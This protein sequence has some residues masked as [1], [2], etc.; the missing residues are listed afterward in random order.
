[1]VGNGCYDNFPMR[2]MMYADLIVRRV[3]LADLAEVKSLAM[4]LAKQFTSIDLV[5]CNAGVMLESRSTTT[6]TSNIEIHQAVNLLS[7]ATLVHFL[8]PSLAE[9]GSR[10]VFV[11]SITAHLG[12]LRRFPIESPEFFCGHFRNGYEAYA[13]SKLA[14]AFYAQELNS[15]FAK[16]TR[17]RGTT[18]VAVHPG[19]VASGLYQHVNFATKLLIRRILKPIMRN[20]ANA[21]A[22]IVA[23]GCCDNLRGGCFYQHMIPVRD[24]CSASDQQRQQI[25][26]QVQRII[27]NI[28]TSTDENWEF[29]ALN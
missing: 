12:N 17:S 19:C 8:L 27:A 11:S 16:S 5:I 4:C 13:T 15:I 29:R 18:V 14:T 7:H 20:P 9:L 6:T 21:A 24:L 25:Y 1:M 3:D 26:E 22:E 28:Q 10:V 2:E 23:L